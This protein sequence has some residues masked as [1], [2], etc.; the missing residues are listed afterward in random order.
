MNLTQHLKVILDSLID[1]GLMLGK[2]IIFAVIVFFVGRYVIKLLNRFI[3][4]VMEHRNID[5][6]VRSFVA[7]LVKVILQVTLFMFIISILGIKTASFITLIA[8]AGFGIGLALNGTLQNFANG[9]LLLLFKPY[10]VGDYIE[11]QGI[12]GTVKAIQIFHTI[13]TTSDNKTIYIPNG[14][15]SSASM[16]NFSQMPSRRIE[17]NIGIEYGEDFE[18]VKKIVL[19]I[20][21]SEKQIMKTPEPLVELNKLADSLAEIVI[22]VW[23]K[24]EEYW[25]VYFSVNQKIYEVFKEKNISFPFP[26]LKVHKG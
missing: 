13:L 7:N 25:N 6:T 26:Q 4:K 18:R 20:L 12:G 1:S 10:K 3:A 16:T 17:W 5:I 8:S 21:N 11:T 19:D 24:S 23:V 22:R 14:T 15:M 2:N 9:V